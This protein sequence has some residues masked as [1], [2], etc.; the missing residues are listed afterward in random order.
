MPPCERIYATPIT[1]CDHPHDHDCLLGPA[2]LS[3]LRTETTTGRA[4]ALLLLRPCGAV[5]RSE[6]DRGCLAERDP[7]FIQLGVSSAL[8]MVS[9]QNGE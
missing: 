4:F 8:I 3:R 2:K 1:E 9:N 7:L 6:P 5:W